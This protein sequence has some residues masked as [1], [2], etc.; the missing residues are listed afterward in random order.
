MLRC[1]YHC[2]HCARGPVAMRLSK[3]RGPSASD[4]R[5]LPTC[6][7]RGQILTNRQI[8]LKIS[9][10]G[11][12]KASRTRAPRHGRAGIQAGAPAVAETTTTTTT[13]AL[14][15]AK[16]PCVCLLRNAGDGSGWAKPWAA[17]PLLLVIVNECAAKLHL[18]LLT[19]KPSC[20]WTSVPVDEHTA[21]LA[22]M[23][24][25]SPAKPREAKQKQAPSLLVLHMM[26]PPPES[27]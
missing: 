11:H 10:S 19:P 9:A 17:K 5:R 13:L 27:S 14:P 24:Q 12:D 21:S 23:L 18:L 15:H 25:P 3:V 22:E 2:Y 20:R 6:Q 26:C 8:S 1:C 7:W 4:R 16:V